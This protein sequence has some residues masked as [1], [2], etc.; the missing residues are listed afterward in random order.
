MKKYFVKLSLSLFFIYAIGLAVSYSNKEAKAG[1]GIAAAITYM[2]S[3]DE[4]AAEFAGNV[5]GAF[6]GGAAAYE[7]GA[8]GAQIGAIGGPL[9]AA[10][11]GALGF[12]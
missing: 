3:E 1:W 2:A 12:L 6:V 7:G 10:I 9:G 5:G 4:E 8:L 11:G